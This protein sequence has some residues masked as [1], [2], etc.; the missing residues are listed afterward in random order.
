MP[1]ICTWQS[2][3]G[4]TL[5]EK[6]KYIMYDLTKFNKPFEEITTVEDRWLYLLKHAGAAENLPDFNDDVIAKAI[7]RLLVKGASVNTLKEQAHA[8]GL[9]EILTIKAKIAK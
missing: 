7:E 4:L 9:A 2:K 8:E 6:N 3:R 1:C 5:S